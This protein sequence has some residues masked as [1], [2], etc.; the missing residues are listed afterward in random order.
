[1]L[2]WLE[3]ALQRNIIMSVNSQFISVQE[4]MKLY[5]QRHFG[6]FLEGGRISWRR[7]SVQLI[8]KAY[9]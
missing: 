6:D 8:L 3:S 7:R 9:E 2:R 1:M 4:Q 5:D